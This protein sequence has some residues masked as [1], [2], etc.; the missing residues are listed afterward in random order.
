MNKKQYILQFKNGE[1]FQKQ[2]NYFK[3]PIMTDNIIQATMFSTTKEAFNVR[4]H[5]DEPWSWNVETV[6]KLGQHKKRKW[7]IVNF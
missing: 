4:E 5:M 3:I 6:R 7:Q 1:F 2:N